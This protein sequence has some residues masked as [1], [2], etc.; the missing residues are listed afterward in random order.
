MLLGR[1]D[2]FILVKF[3]YER[4]AAV[5]RAMVSAIGLID[6]A[7]LSLPLIRRLAGTCVMYGRPESRGPTQER[8][9]PG[10]APDVSRPWIKACS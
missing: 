5:R 4:S 10:T 3:N 8:L 6:Y 1:L 2:R 9:I 7:L